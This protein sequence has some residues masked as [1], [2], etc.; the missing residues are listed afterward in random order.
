MKV[1]RIVNSIVLLIGFSGPWLKSCGA[2][3][4]TGWEITKI[5][6]ELIPVIEF[7]IGEFIE[8]PLGILAILMI[9]PFLTI[10]AYAIVSLLMSIIGIA[11]Q[12]LRTLRVLLLSTSAIGL[13]IPLLF[14]T[15]TPQFTVED[16]TLIWGYW[17]TLSGIG[18][19]ISVEIVDY[20]N[21]PP[22][23]E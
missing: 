7:N 20:R 9:L 11:P 17:L 4:Y 14:I 1:L 10:P 22:P 13:S 18:S 21:R 15:I 23:P 16:V 3:T 8:E 6:L 2:S 5:S 19:S 12:K